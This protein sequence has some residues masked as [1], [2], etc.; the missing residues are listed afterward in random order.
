MNNLYKNFIEFLPLKKEMTFLTYKEG[1][2][3]PQK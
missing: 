1:S 3:G 2:L